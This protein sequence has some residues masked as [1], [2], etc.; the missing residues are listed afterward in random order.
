MPCDP[1]GKWL[2]RP[3]S[4]T[5]QLAGN[6]DLSVDEFAWLGNDGLVF[7]ADEKGGTPLHQVF[8]S[9]PGTIVTQGGDGTAT[10]LS[11]SRDGQEIA[12]LGAALNRP[13]EVFTCARDLRSAVARNVSHANDALLAELDLPGR[14]A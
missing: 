5:G 12:Y 2:G 6:R 14:R 10:T 8:L 3:V 7:A 11:T 4:V 9:S 13:A 1:S